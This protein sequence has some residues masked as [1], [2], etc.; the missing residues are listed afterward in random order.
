MKRQSGT[1]YV[2]GTPIGNLEDITYRAVRTLQQS[3]LILAENG[4]NS[5]KLAVSLKIETPIKQL[6]AS[7]KEED[8]HW[9]WEI[10][11]EGN[12][13]SYISDAGTPG[14]SDPGANLVRYCR[15]RKI[16]ISPIPGPSSLTALLSVSGWQTNPS[17]FL[18]FLP[19]KNSQK[20]TLL[21]KFVSEECLI[22]VF[23]SVYR[24]QNLLELLREVYPEAEILVGR[25]LTKSYEEITLIS[26]AE[27][28]PKL[29]AKGEFAVI[30]NNRLKKIAKERKT[31]ADI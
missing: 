19:D 31:E 13:V 10:F 1:L 25:E 22:V 21:Q 4:A 9:L 16:P 2:V 7:T 24:I 11:E 17:H 5:K 8:L 14:V 3:S 29:T 15:K 23:E 12:D 20:K 28:I 26:P 18:G 6:Y 30:V 27:A